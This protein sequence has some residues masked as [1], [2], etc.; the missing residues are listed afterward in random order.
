MFRTVSHKMH[1]PRLRLH[2]QEGLYHTTDSTPKHPN[3]FRGPPSLILN[4]DR[5]VHS[6][7]VQLPRRKADHSTP[8][9]VEIKNEWR[10]SLRPA[11]AFTSCIE[12]LSLSPHYE[13]V[14]QIRRN[15]L[16]MKTSE[17]SNKVLLSSFWYQ[18][19]SS[20][21]LFLV[22]RRLSKAAFSRSFWRLTKLSI[23]EVKPSAR[24]NKGA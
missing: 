12:Q 23:D 24:R 17:A 11:L 8:P 2:L 5:R 16:K 21:S 14:R 20:L 3:L 6:P 1:K 10:Y 13:L 15:G 4:A 19:L 9:S 7:G 22:P 18:E